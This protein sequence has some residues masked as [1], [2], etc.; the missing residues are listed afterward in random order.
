MG[1]YITHSGR[2]IDIDCISAKDICIE[3]IAHHLT[4]ICR[5]GGALDLGVHYSVAYHSLRLYHYL[6]THEYSV[7]LQRAALMHDASEAYLGD[8][9]TGL[10]SHLPDYKNLEK[11]VQSLINEKYLIE[12]EPHQE[13][14]LKELDTRIRL[15][16]ALSF[17]P[18]HYEYFI[19][20]S[21]YAEPLGIEIVPE[22]NLQMTYYLFLYVC[23]KLN[24]GD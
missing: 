10:K 17:A 20:Q 8:I 19:N 21:L 5:Y 18:H 16:E 15:D 2:T 9:V 13:D 23:K 12:L 22:T 14:I 1:Y 11:K 4:K 7:A 3:D 24:L 6:K